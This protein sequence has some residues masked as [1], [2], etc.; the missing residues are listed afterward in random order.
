M[1]SNMGK[2]QKIVRIVSG[3][4]VVGAAAATH[5]WL[6]GVVGGILLLSGAAGYCPLCSLGK[7]SCHMEK[8]DGNKDSKEGGCCGPK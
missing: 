8:H 3:I 6:L 1:K 4:V 2:T 7:G 5:N